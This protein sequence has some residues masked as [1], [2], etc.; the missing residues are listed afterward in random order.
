[1]EDLGG[2][3]ALS[4]EGADGEGVVA[5]GEA[6][7]V[8]VREQ[9]GVEVNGRWEVEGALKEELAGSGFEKVAAADYFGNLHVCAVGGAG[10]LVAGEA[11]VRRVVAKGF[12]PDKEVAKVF[13]CGKGLGT[14]LRSVKVTG[15]PSGTRN[16]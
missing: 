15:A 3:K 6:S 13:A 16:R 11:G 9:L 12:A 10:E 5:L 1:L 7:A 2:R 4:P 8:L 14:R